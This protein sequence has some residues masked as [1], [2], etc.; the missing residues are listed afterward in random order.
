MAH[1]VTHPCRDCVSTDCVTACPVDAFHEGKDMLYINAEECICC[2]A[3]ISE[4][5]VDAI[6]AEEDVPD[7]WAEYIDLNRQLAPTLPNITEIKRR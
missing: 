1:V 6:Y 3:C 4:C 5:P 2:D 7:Q